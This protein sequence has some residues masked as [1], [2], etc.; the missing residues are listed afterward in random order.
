M[1]AKAEFENWLV[2]VRFSWQ[3]LALNTGWFRFRLG[4]LGGLLFVGPNIQINVFIVILKPLYMVSNV[5]F[6]FSEKKEQKYYGF[7][8]IF[9]KL[10]VKVKLATICKIN[11]QNQIYILL[12]ISFTVPDSL[13]CYQSWLQENSN[14]EASFQKWR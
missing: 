2:Y 8:L 12:E 10:S 5:N 6:S 9:S 13:T 11:D 14:L 4:H 1:L 3:V 7:H